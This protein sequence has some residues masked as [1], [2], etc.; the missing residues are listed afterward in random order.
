MKKILLSL[1][2]IL[3]AAGVNAQARYTVPVR[4]VEEKN[5]NLVFQMWDTNKGAGCRVLVVV[6]QI[7]LIMVISFP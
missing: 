4:T 1:I 6:V 7:N 3:F 5:Q 2:W